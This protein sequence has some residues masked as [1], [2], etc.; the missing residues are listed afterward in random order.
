MIHLAY[1]A[2]LGIAHKFRYNVSPFL[3]RDTVQMRVKTAPR[4][5]LP[6]VPLPYQADLLSFRSVLTVQQTACNDD[7]QP[8]IYGTSE[9]NIARSQF[10]STAIKTSSSQQIYGM[11]FKSKQTGAAS[12]ILALFAA[13]IMLTVIVGL[14]LGYNLGYKRGYHALEAENKKAINSSQMTVQELEEMRASYKALS[15][16][17]AVA[18]QE[19]TISLNNLDELRENQKELS[20]ENKQLNQ[21][22]EVYAEAL[23]EE[24]GLPLQVLG[25]RIE[26]LPENAFEFGFDV[27]ML[28]RDGQAKRLNATLTLL[29]DDDFVEVPLDSASY[30]LEGITR[31]RGR[32]VMPENFKPLQVKLVL[33]ADGQEV[34]Q[35]YDWT[36]GDRVDSMP[37]SLI[38]LP[39]VDQSPI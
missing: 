27:A 3:L 13:A 39:E 20:V 11:G 21:L 19:L 36:L 1:G 28:S 6:P 37:L 22:N 8:S 32:F 5:R 17:V 14:I 33:T 38:D 15:N 16:Q 25:A 23:S 31:I 26:P 29:N 10:K 34:E 2:M 9:T 18:K 4:L 24:G 30:M 12:W 35:L 7:T